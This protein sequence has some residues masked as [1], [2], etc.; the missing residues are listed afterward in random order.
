MTTT[1]AYT[2]DQR[3]LDAPHSD[4][5]RARSAA[6]SVIPTST[7][8][9]KAIG[10]VIPELKGKLDGIAMRVPVPDGSVVDLVVN[11]ERAAS[12]EEIN[13]AVRERA[14]TGPLE[15]ILAYTEDPIVSQD[16]VGSTLLLGLRLPADDG[17]REARQGRRLVRQRVRLLQP[18]RR[19]R[20][21]HP[22]RDA[23]DRRP[24]RPARA[25]RAR[26]RRPQRAARGRPRGRRHAH[27]GRAADA[28]RRCASSGAR[29]VVCSHLGRPKG[30]P[31][32]AYSLCPVAARLG[33]LL[34]DDRRLR[35]GLRRAGR[36]ARPSRPSATATSL[37]L[38]NLRFH[39]GETANDPAFA[40]GPRRAR[41]RVRE[42]RVRRRAPRARLDRGRRA[43]CCRPPPA[44]LLLR[45]VE[46]LTGAAGVARAA[47]R[48]HRRRRQ[49]VGQDR[50]RRPA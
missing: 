30:A 50:R 31:D 27:P 1:H 16:I 49:G 11:L 37:L 18:A 22:A 9:A 15:G 35:R 48:G 5:R 32:P 21:T 47:V 13:A 40:P 45:E 46:T 23:R 24:R 12:V 42:R 33:E 36:R 29:V 39:A 41:R 17:Q 20:R 38:E 7:G 19:P 44:T 14:D 2:G 25:A 26:A 6:M 4:L 8:A 10:L 28:A 34:G 3:L 43:S